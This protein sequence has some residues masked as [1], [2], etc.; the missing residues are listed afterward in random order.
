MIERTYHLSSYL[1]GI[2]IMMI[3]VF[4]HNSYAQNE[5]IS[6]S[7][8]DA[9]NQTKSAEECLPVL[10]VMHQQLD[11][12]QLS[13]EI[14]NLGLPPEQRTAFVYH[15]LI[16]LAEEDQ[17]EIMQ[18]L[19]SRQITGN[20]N[21]WIVNAVAV[22]LPEALIYEIA[23]R[24]DV[25][26]LELNELSNMQPARPVRIEPS[27]TRDVG[28]AE[29]GLKAIRA[30]FMWQLGYSGRGKVLYSIDTGVWPQHPGLG[31]RFMGYFKPMDQA[32]HGFDSP[33]PVDK[34]GTHGTHTIGTILGLDEA[35]H[36]SIGAAMNSYFI[37]S[38]PVATDMA[39]VR[40]LTDFI[41]A[42]EWA[43]NPD[44][45]TNTWN[46]VPAVINNSWG[47]DHATT[48]T[49][50]N[51]YASDMFGNLELAGIANVFSA[52]NSG[53]GATTIGMPQHITINEITCFTVGALNANVVG[54]PIATFSSRGPGVCPGSGAVLIR[55]EVAAPGED[56]RSAINQTQYAL[57]SGTSMAAPHVSG[58]VLLLKEAFPFLTGPEILTAL[59][60][61]ADDLGDPGEDNTYGNGMINLENAYNYLSTYYTPV[62]PD[63]KWDVAIKQ[64]HNPAGQF[65][66]GNSFVPSILIGNKGTNDV[67]NLKIYSIHN[68]SL[69]DTYDYTGTL[70]AGAEQFVVL[71][72][73]D[74]QH[75]GLNEFLFAVEIDSSEME[76]DPINNYRR[77]EVWCL[78]EMQLPFFEGFEE[79]GINDTVWANVNPDADLKWDTAITSGITG[80]TVSAVLRCG[81]E[82][83]FY[84]QDHLVSPA[85]IPQNSGGAFTLKFDVAYQ[86]RFAVLSDTLKVGLS[87]D[88]GVSFPYLIYAKGG[89][90]LSTASGSQIGFLPSDSS[91]WRTETIDLSAYSGSG[92]L[93]LKF[94]GVNRKG[95]NIVLDNIRMFEGA[96][97]FSVPEN[98]EVSGIRIF[99]NP[100]TNVLNIVFDDQMP[101]NRGAEIHDVTGKLVYTVTQAEL[102]S[103]QID[104]SPIPSGVYFLHLAGQTDISCRF[105]K[106]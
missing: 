23:M 46:D 33:I 61:S 92:S 106:R 84:K 40:P 80:S 41:L 16:N 29:Q 44:G 43:F 5:K 3:S 4:Y 36:D 85:L 49:L 27:E 98:T 55:P 83:D 48:D 96:D 38:D 74:I 58:A 31:G 66:C 78:P 105:V 13:A 37:S 93:M 90:T 21:L 26:L 56:V 63:Y 60:Y 72:P 54:Y 68:G 17:N 32:W 42:F 34:S 15:A 28:F 11:Y 70:I 94:T 97:P 102:S 100:A 24:S 25:E 9:I 20:R 67:Q 52:G 45:D 57:Y 35:T 71:P 79:A 88:C 82:T 99:P 81:S 95:N 87:T 30:D 77:A 86:H 59:Y 103:H 50:C 69:I 62:S 75:H 89:A 47:Y 73:I 6:Q 64:L 53:P 104:I 10:I 14:K 39:Y 91:H 101:E 51:S 8:R 7:L 22:E 76:I 2:L 18:F 19:H 1:T 65:M 12:Q